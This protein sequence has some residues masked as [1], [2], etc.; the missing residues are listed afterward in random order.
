MSNLLGHGVVREG[1]LVGVP[2]LL[3][4]HVSEEEA[5]G[6]YSPDGGHVLVGDAHHLHGVL[7]AG[8]LLHVVDAGDPETAS[9]HEGV[10]LGIIK[11]HLS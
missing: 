4:L 9:R 3:E 7:S 11:Q 2:L 6:D 10:V 5:G 8:E 1:G